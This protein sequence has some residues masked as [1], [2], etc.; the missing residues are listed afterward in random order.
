MRQIFDVNYDMTERSIAKNLFIGVLEKNCGE[1]LKN[2]ILFSSL[3]FLAV[4]MLK[5]LAK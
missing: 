5:K 2:H 4:L 1:M 3:P